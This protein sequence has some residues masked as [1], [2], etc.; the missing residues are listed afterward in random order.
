MTSHLNI[1]LSDEFR[2]I[3]D[4]KRGHMPISIFVRLQLAKALGVD[5]KIAVS[6][7][8]RTSEVKKNKK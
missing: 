5:E 4:K 7:R 1:S 6:E 8:E 3:I 2:E